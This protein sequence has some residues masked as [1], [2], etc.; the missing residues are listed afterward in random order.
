MSTG[1]EFAICILPIIMTA[2]GFILFMGFDY[3][4]ECIKNK[5]L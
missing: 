4:G 3:V 5:K 2:I 1:T